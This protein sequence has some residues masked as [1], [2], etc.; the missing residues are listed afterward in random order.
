MMTGL[1]IARQP[2]IHGSNKMVKLAPDPPVR[3]TMLVKLADVGS[4]A[5]CR[6]LRH[7]TMSIK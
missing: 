6:R 3:H 5:E 2:S 4:G 1:L 7:A